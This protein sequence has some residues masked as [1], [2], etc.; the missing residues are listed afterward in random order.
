M[1]GLVSRIVD[2]F[3]L[4]LGRRP[5]G[6]MPHKTGGPAFPVLPQ[7]LALA[8]G[9]AV[10]PFLNHYIESHQWDVSWGAIVAQIFF[11]FLMGAC[12]FPGVYRNAF[13]RSKPMFVQ[14]CA[15]FTSGLGW[16]S[17]FKTG[18]AAGSAVTTALTS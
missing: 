10:Q 18:V 16:E 12:I 7:Y 4:Q 15:I 11:G 2:Y 13:D 8:A 9:V 5:V 1:P 14:L 17:L 6:A 3:D